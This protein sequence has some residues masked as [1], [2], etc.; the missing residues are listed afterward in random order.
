VF[1]HENEA[2]HPNDRRSNSHKLNVIRSI[3]RGNGAVVYEIVSLFDDEV[4]AYR[5]E[6]RLISLWGRLHAG[7]PLTNRA[8]GG[9]SVA[10]PSPFSRERHAATLG[11][12]PEDDPET[13]TLN[14][15]V[16]SIGTM[17]SVVLKPL[18][19]F[20]PRPTRPFER[21]SRAPSLRQAIA[22]AATA[23]A[24]GIPLDNEA[25]L[26]RSVVIDCVD[27]FVENGVAR[28]ITTSG[29]AQ[30]VPAAT[31]LNEAFA[32]TRQQ[33]AQVIGFIG[34]KKAVEL[35]LLERLA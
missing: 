18:S 1:Q 9:G 5:E 22:L 30:L 34:R 2:T 19:R 15:F 26:S 11:G 35:G 25:L 28:D 31:P 20:T 12:I 14:C 13:A 32:L 24:N 17:R 29:M 10:E 8:P 33:A 4:S 27:A 23:S 16:L 21:S 3:K 7:G 6:E